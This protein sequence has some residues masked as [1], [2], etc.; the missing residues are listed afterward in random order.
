MG[1]LKGPKYWA[2]KY[3]E[4]TTPIAEVPVHELNVRVMNVVDVDLLSGWLE[5]EKLGAKR[6]FAMRRI[7]HRV[8]VLKRKRD[9]AEL[10][11]ISKRK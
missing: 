6:Q 11:R 5:A 8:S 9:L 10:D 4:D 3:R 1:S 2:A 7:Y